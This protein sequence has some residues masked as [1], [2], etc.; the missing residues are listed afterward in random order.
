[1]LLSACSKALNRRESVCSSIPMPVS[2]TVMLT[3]QLPDARGLTPSLIVTLP[4]S[5]NL[6]AFESRFDTHWRTRTGS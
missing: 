4:V 6:M 2:D 5:V 3:A 1:M